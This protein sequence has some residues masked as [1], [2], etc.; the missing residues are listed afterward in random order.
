MT[1]SKR[2]GLD[3]DTVC[4]SLHAR[5]SNRPGAPPLVK[6]RAVCGPGDD[7]SQVITILC[8]DEDRV[9]NG[10]AGYRFLFESIGRDG[11]SVRALG[12]DL[13][14]TYPTWDRRPL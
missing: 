8:L 6:L 2:E 7:P 4:F 5:N 12:R 14:F 1:R 9:G 3:N 13:R 10:S 11:A